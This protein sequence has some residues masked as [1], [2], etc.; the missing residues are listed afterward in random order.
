MTKIKNNPILKG[1]SG[2][3]GDV[4]VYRELRDGRLIMANRPKKPEVPSE[5]QLLAKSRFLRAVQYAKGQMADPVASV[6]YNALTN[7]K[8]TSGYALAV[9]DFLKGPEINQVNTSDYTGVVGNMIVITAFDNF[10][11]NRVRV[12]IRS[13]AGALIEQGDAVPNEGNNLLWE[14]T[15][16][17]ANAA[18]TGTRLIISATD[19]PGNIT[20]QEVV[21]P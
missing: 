20:T 5:N 10:R 17:Q 9:A 16:T 4:I 3:L 21:L 18:V 13:A 7:A 1:A 19:R 2:M 6:E 12:E 11:V 15:V 8:L 14:Y